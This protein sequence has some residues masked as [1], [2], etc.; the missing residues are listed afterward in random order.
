MLSLFFNMNRLSVI[1]ECTLVAIM[2]G[3]AS[4]KKFNFQDAYIFSRH[5]YSKSYRN[6]PSKQNAIANESSF[7]DLELLQEPI[8][9]TDNHHL[10]S[11]IS[12]ERLNLIPDENKGL[13]KRII[14]KKI[15]KVTQDYASNN[16]KVPQQQIAGY[17][18][19]GMILGGTGVLSLIVG[20]LFGIGFLIT[21]GVLL[22]IG[23][24]VYV[25]LDFL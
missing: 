18:R 9:V 2:Y 17:F 24:I 10:N 5:D 11:R 4:S 3:C 16:K 14:K 23:G 21:I 22:I 15:A 8:Y 13:S 25:I 1:V 19:T 7:L 6:E 12:P 20:S